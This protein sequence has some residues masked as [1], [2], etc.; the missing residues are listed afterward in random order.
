[1]IPTPGHF[2]QFLGSHWG[3]IFCIDRDSFLYCPVKS[4]Y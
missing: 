1:M 3:W 2:L 4:C